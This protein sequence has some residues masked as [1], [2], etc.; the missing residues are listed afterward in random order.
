[1]ISLWLDTRPQYV[2]FSHLNT[3]NGLTENNVQSL[4]VDKNGFLWI[5][6]TEGL[7]LY[8]GYSISNFKKPEYPQMASNNVIHLTCDSRN[9]LWLGTPE[10]IT[11]IDSRRNFHR[12]I[13]NDT[14][15]VFASRTIMDTKLYGPVLFT[16]LGQYYLEESSR[17]W[18]RL[19]WIPGLLRYNRFHDSEP[20]DENQVIY[21]TDSLVLILDYKLQKIIYDQPFRNVVSVCRYSEYEIAIGFANGLVKIVDTR[22]KKINQ[23]YQLTGVL[24]KKKIN[25][26]ITEVRKAPNGD[27][28]V[29]TGFSGLVI[30]DKN[31]KVSHYTHDPLDP[32]SIGANITWRVLGGNN[33]DMIVGTSVAGVS[34]FN[35]YNK[36]AGYTRIFNDGRGDAYDNH[37]TKLVEDKKGRIWMGALD[38]LIRWDKESRDVK[39]FYYYS[40]R[41][42]GTNP[43][44]IEIRTLCIDRDGR[45]WAGALGDGIAVLNEASG[46]FKKIPID[47]SKG[48]ALRTKYIH[49]LYAASDGLIWVGGNGGP[50]TIHPRSLQVAAFDN[51]PQFRALNRVRVTCFM[52]DEEN[53]LWIG[54]FNGVYCYKRDR[55]TLLHYSEKEGL[56]SN[57]CFSLMQASNGNIYVGTAAGFSIIQPDGQVKKYG[58]EEGL[59]YDYVAG[60]QQDRSGN[61]W[62]ANGKA[63]IRFDS[64]MNKMSVFDENVGLSTD[65]FRVNSYLSSKK[66]EM[67]WGS[68]AGI[69]YFYPDQLE[70]Y[71]SG[72]R[73]HI[74]QADKGD[75]T[76]FVESGE[77]IPLRYSDNDI[78]FRFSAINLKGSKNISYQ[79]LL[80]GYDKH[81][82]S[83]KDIREARYASLPPGKYTFKLRASLDG[84]NWINSNNSVN[85]GIVAPVWQRWWFIL[86]CLGL[87][88]S[89]IFLF[90][91]NRTQK[92]RLQ[93]EQ[94]ETE[95]AINYFATSLNEQRTVDSILW[96]VARNCIGRLQF[97]DCVIYLLDEE[98][99]VLVQKAAHGPK[100]PSQYEIK[101][102]LEIPV[103]KGIVGSVAQ[104]AKAEIIND[105]TKDPRYIVDD[106][107]RYSEITVPIMADGKL[108]GIIDCEHSKKGFFTQ[109]HLSILTTIASLCANKIVKANAEAEK[110]E[111]ERILMDTQQKMSEVEMQALRAQMNPHFIFNCLNSINRY[112]VKS[113]QAT[114]SLYLTK[115]AK[116]IRLILDNSNS[117]NV[118]LTNELEAL[119]LYIDMESLRF[120]KKFTY[121]IVVDK[122]VSTDSVEV[123]PLIIQPYVENAIWHGLLHKQSAGHLT[124]HVSMPADG[125][126]RCVIEDNGVGREKAKELKSKT[127]TTKKSLGMKLTE[128]RLSL[129]NKH[130]ELN[131]SVEIIDLY[132]G[133]NGSTEAAGTKVILNIP[134]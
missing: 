20:F 126:L 50:Y 60:I 88:A 109:R 131:A 72:I 65:G 27:L 78:I 54:A 32:R 53:N 118:I 99:S 85:V 37:V 17:K 90:I 19:N 22:S 1:M 86:I 15:A 114:A 16:S 123:P 48:V 29:G 5:G 96:D 11:W 100:N 89:V 36:Q 28:L 94:L 23:Q 12:V 98:R 66:G 43:V 34:I 44:N 117:K 59:I 120:D 105:T 130:A 39:F 79:Y 21:A 52:E 62:V 58:K 42:A 45:I 134:V 69:N 97:E 55:D 10:G 35:V 38:R 112:I 40:D 30:I 115:F 49:E 80:E 70:S 125:M 57:R 121:S 31:G 91:R 110:R 3:S 56:A 84:V 111:A 128:N 9:R 77:T 132:N 63:I 81:W 104:S 107:R 67:F 127:A 51:H 26:T 116:L 133:A 25:A 68:R 33:G 6:T 13:L 102:A 83:G 122:T 61:I 93:R 14:S 64:G 4:A 47:T 41:P 103:G 108:L 129:L 73:V 74:Y 76:L 95:K 113:D 101:G 82:Q 92:M 8:D 119:K 106:E 2:A 124:I 87:I 75:T 7:N 18:R 46:Q 71:A 24:N